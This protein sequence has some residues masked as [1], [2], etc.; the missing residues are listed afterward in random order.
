[1]SVWSLNY[2]LSL[3]TFLKK[4]KKGNDSDKKKKKEK[5]D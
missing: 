5:A 3:D 1:R 2:N 4:L